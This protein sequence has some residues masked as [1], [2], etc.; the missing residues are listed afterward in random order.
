MSVTKGNNIEKIKNFIINDNCKNLLINE[1]S[2]EISLF[3]ILVINNIAKENGVKLL[4]ETEEKKLGN[5]NDLFDQ[6]KIQIFNTSN[7]KKIGEMLNKKFQKIMIC[8]YKNYKKFSKL[9]ETINSYQFENDIR[10]YLEN[11]FKINH[12][13]LINFCISQPHF[14]NSEINKYKINDKKYLA[15]PKIYEVENFILEIRKEIF[16]TKNSDINIKKLFF[17]LKK[18]VKYKKF[19]FLTF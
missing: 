13:E 14:M 5:M 17:M 16:K 7:S 9:S 19:N 1:F 12:E 2:E 8:D 4:R 6:K 15:Y 3:Y 10:Y 18:E 11:N